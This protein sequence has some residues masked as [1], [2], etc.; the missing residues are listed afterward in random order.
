MVTENL[1][2]AEEYEAQQEKN[3]C[4]VLEAESTRA[5]AKRPRPTARARKQSMSLFWQVFGSTIVS[6]VALLMI[7]AY[8][9][10]TA[11]DAE[12]RRDVAQIQAELVRKDELNGRLTALWNSVRDLENTRITVIGLG[13]QAKVLGKNL[14][15]NIKTEADRRSELQRQV[16]DLS[17]RLQ[18][19][20][21]RLASVETAHRV[22]DSQRDANRQSAN[23]TPR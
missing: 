5:A 14:E 11:T 8:S 6:V 12:L 19:L 17:R 18:A 7:T 20:A 16:D 13:D 2:R 4:T 1:L 3:R 23:A 9:Q 15:S 10:M 21:E 22:A